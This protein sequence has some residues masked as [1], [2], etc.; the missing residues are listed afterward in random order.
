VTTLEKIKIVTHQAYW[1]FF[2]PGV[3]IIAFFSFSFRSEWFSFP[4][5]ATEAIFLT[6]F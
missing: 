1:L 2:F 6:T 5:G 4:I 3:I